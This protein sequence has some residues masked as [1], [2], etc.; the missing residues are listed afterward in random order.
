M[1]WGRVS[2]YLCRQSLRL[3]G[4]GRADGLPL[5]GAVGPCGPPSAHPLEKAGGAEADG[6]GRRR[7]RREARIAHPLQDGKVEGVDGEQE[8][9]RGSHGVARA[10]GAALFGGLAVGCVVHCVDN[11]KASLADCKTIDAESL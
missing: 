9:L 6:L 11:P 5:G 2:P 8:A 7:R 4:R 10:E 1:L 3:A